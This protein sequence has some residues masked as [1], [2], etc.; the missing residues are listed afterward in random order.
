MAS[1]VVYKIVQ[2]SHQDNAD[3]KWHGIHLPTTLQ[4]DHQLG[5]CSELH[6]LIRICAS[7]NRAYAVVCFVKLRLTEMGCGIYQTKSRTSL[8]RLR[9]YE[10]KSSRGIQENYISDHAHVKCRM[11][12]SAQCPK[13]RIPYSIHVCTL[14][15]D[16]AIRLQLL[17][18]GAF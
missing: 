4:N 7:E 18:V 12:N 1:V 11:P 3:E 15:Q 5:I 13:H 10:M 16:R 9:I 6:L 2:G 17:P 8:M 14:D